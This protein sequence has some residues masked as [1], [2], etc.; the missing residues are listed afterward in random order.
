MS[1]DLYFIPLIASTVRQQAPEDALCRAFVEIVARG[2][3]PECENGFRQFLQFMGIAAE[4]LELMDEAA[5]RRAIVI[6]ATG[7]GDMALPNTDA[8]MQVI[9]QNPRWKRDYEQLL[10]EV[11]ESLNPTDFD[12]HL[13]DGNG[14]L[15]GRVRLERDVPP[16]TISNVAPGEYALA[17]DTGWVIWEGTLTDQD[18]IWA[19]AFP[20]RPLRLAADTGEAQLQPTVEESLLRGELILRVFPGLESGHLEIEVR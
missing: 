4:R 18:L 3:Q 13:L 6:L 20:G 7:G 1:S 19:A 2:Q 12:V 5:L 11:E 16:R 8:T 17:L 9:R 10:V 15:L 14:A